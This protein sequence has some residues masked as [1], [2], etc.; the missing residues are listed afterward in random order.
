MEAKYLKQIRADLA[1]VAVAFVWGVTFVVVQDALADISPHYFNAI[2]FSLACA[3]LAI[4]YWR[5][6][7]GISRSTLFTGMFIGLFLFAG[8]AFQT[9]GL[10][11]T[12]ASNSGF[13]TSM[14]VVLV[15][16]MTAIILRRVPTLYAIIGTC[17]ATLGLALLSLSQGL[18]Q[19]NF[20]DLLT[21]LCAIGFALHI[22]MVGK[23]APQHDSALL[24]ITQIGTVAVASL[25]FGVFTE[26]PP[27][28]FTSSVWIAL[29]TTAIFATALAFL[30]QNT[31]Q[32]FTSPTHT[33]IIFT[34]EPVFAAL[35]AFLFAGELLTRNQLIGCGLILAGML[36]AELCGE[37]DHENVEGTV[38]GSVDI[39]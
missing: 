38:R 6:L 5:R 17:C 24:T 36:I 13:I 2:R 29:L 7:R 27:Q 18:S 28:T 39:N 20:G 10:Q 1:L 31:V 16:I 11:Y 15:P 25:V 12:S 23:Y 8:Y 3:F 37:Q 22:I 14:S 21:F 34:L 33:A 35:T 4:F 19:I 30:I 26:A 32:K 9:V